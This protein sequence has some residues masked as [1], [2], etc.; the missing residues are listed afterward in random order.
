MLYQVAGRQPL[1]LQHRIDTAYAETQVLV[2]NVIWHLNL[3]SIYLFVI[4]Q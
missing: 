3:D 1:A 2:M 4:W